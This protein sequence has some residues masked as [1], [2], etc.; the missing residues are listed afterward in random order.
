ML[1]LV[2]H[3]RPFIFSV[4]SWYLCLCFTSVLAL[5]QSSLIGYASKNKLLPRGERGII[6]SRDLTNLSRFGVFMIV[7]PHAGTVVVRS[8]HTLVKPDITDRTR[9]QDMCEADD[10][11]PSRGDRI[12]S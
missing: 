12:V 3:I 4:V 1:I 9:F 8:Q 6:V 11:S 5:W 2:L 7:G 10:K